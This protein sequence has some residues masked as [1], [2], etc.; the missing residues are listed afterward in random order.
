MTIYPILLF[1]NVYSVIQ[2]DM[3]VVKKQVNSSGSHLLS[4]NIQHYYHQDVDMMDN[5][6]QTNSFL[7][8]CFYI[9]HT[10]THKDFAWIYVDNIY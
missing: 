1:K 6:V 9:T 7:P 3:M 4:I 8:S 2:T 5:F 10:H